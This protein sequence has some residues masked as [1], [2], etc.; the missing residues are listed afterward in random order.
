[1]LEVLHVVLGLPFQVDTG[2]GVPPHPGQ[3]P[4]GLPVGVQGWSWHLPPLFL[5]FLEQ[6][7]LAHASSH[8]E[9]FHT[10][11]LCPSDRG[12]L[13]LPQVVR[14]LPLATTELLKTAYV[15]ERGCGQRAA[16]S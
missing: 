6:L 3:P 2:A 8:R 14:H 4:S 9:C 12:G 1:M 13:W 5:Y 16:R 7:F 10:G 11:A 15:L